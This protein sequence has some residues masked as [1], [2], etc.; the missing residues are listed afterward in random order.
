MFLGYPV[1]DEEQHDFAERHDANIGFC[2]LNRVGTRVFDVEAIQEML[3]LIGESLRFLRTSAASGTSAASTAYACWF[4]ESARRDGAAATR[5]AG[6]YSAGFRVVIVILH[7]I[8]RL[9]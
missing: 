6:G 2:Q 1:R 5:L 3:Q 4:R 8:G 7:V 9:M